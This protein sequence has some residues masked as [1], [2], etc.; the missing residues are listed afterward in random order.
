VGIFR[1]K[2][3]RGSLGAELSGRLNQALFEQDADHEASVT[4]AYDLSAEIAEASLKRR[5]A[6]VL[7][8]DLRVPIDQMLP[9]FVP[10]HALAPVADAATEGCLTAHAETWTELDLE[11][12]EQLARSGCE[13]QARDLNEQ[14]N[15]PR[16][17]A[18]TALVGLLASR[19]GHESKRPIVAFKPLYEY[20]VSQPSYG[21]LSFLGAQ[22]AEFAIA[23]FVPRALDQDEVDVIRAGQSAAWH[24]G[25]CVWLVKK[26]GLGDRLGSR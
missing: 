18:G 19:P 25:V 12:A 14:A 20:V 5:G 22:Q 16:Y 17:R 26:A 4:E 3:G 11:R 24:L 8:R 21:R 15:Q 2:S 6:D 10:W 9:N 1:S 7:P 13:Q 23:H